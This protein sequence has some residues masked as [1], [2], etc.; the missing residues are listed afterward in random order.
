[1][2]HPKVVTLKQT[3]VKN[4]V[5]TKGEYRPLLRRIAGFFF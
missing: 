5:G 1:M 2:F 4:L 3:V